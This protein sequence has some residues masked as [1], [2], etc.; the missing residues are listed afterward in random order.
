MDKHIKTIENVLKNKNLSL[1]IFKFNNT[2]DI[3]NICQTNKKFNTISQN[4]D[5][6]FGEECVNYFFSTSIIKRYNILL[7]FSILI[8]EF[9]S[10][11]NSLNKQ[12]WKNTFKTAMQTRN[13]WSQFDNKNLKN[14]KNEDINYES[15]TS[16]TSHNNTNSLNLEISQVGSEVYNLLKGKF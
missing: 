3:S 16:Y 4:L 13:N 10:N 15:D 12:T 5:H 11:S 7:K 6:Y 14:C 2:K 8:D 9:D 1:S